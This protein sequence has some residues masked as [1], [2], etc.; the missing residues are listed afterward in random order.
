MSSSRR[1]GGGE[2]STLESGN[3]LPMLIEGN[4]GV[5]WRPIFLGDAKQREEF[6][7]PGLAAWQGSQSD[8]DDCSAVS[9]ASQV[10]WELAA[11][12]STSVDADAITVSKYRGRRSPGFRADMEKGERELKKELKQLHKDTVKAQQNGGVMGIAMQS[13][14]HGDLDTLQKRAK[15]MQQLRTISNNIATKGRISALQYGKLLKKMKWH[16]AARL[17]TMLSD[18]EL[19]EMQLLEGAGL[20]GNEME[21]AVVY[22]RIKEKLYQ[23]QAEKSMMKIREAQKTTLHNGERPRK[24][25]STEAASRRSFKAHEC[26]EKALHKGRFFEQ[27]R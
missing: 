12:S 10:T 19:Q 7:Y 14:T 27:F 22:Y 21:A 6:I 9:A 16:K 11:S 5:V 18:K 23:Q 8:C 1:G 2:E 26:V 3:Y 20:Q 24:K 13:K 4:Q 25:L 17:V 15:Q